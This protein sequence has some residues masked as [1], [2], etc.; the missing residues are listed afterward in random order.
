MTE[1][2]IVSANEAAGLQDDILSTPELAAPKAEP[3]AHVGVIN[4]VTIERF[5]NEKQ[6]VALKFSLTS[7]NVPTLD[8]EYSLFLPKQFAENIN[9]D[10]T[11]L[12]AEEGNN[13]KQQYAIGIANDTKDA[14]LQVLRRIAYEQG[15][16]LQG[17]Q[18]PTNLE[19]FVDVLNALLSGVEVVFVRRPDKKADDPRFRNRLRVQGFYAPSVVNNPKMLKNYRKMWEEVQG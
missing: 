12:P 3:D 9:V 19:E 17:M 8:Q 16:S 1:E 4:G 5:D 15:R 10:P 18:R 7:R 2:T 13:Q 14:T 11:T 6:S